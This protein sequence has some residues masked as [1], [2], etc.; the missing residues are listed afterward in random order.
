[1]INRERLVSYAAL[2]LETLNPK[3]HPSPAAFLSGAPLR[4]GLAIESTESTIVHCSSD[5][6]GEDLSV[7]ALLSDSDLITR[8]SG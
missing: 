8:P 7:V 6:I 5:L 4:A 3:K 1:M 2:V